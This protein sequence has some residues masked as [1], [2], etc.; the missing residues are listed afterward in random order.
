MVKCAQKLY[1]SCFI[2]KY[3]ASVM[4]KIKFS[5]LISWYEKMPWDDIIIMPNVFWFDFH[6]GRKV[7]VFGI[8]I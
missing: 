1:Q 3:N 4:H 7:M 8:T 5:Y 6:I 2:Q